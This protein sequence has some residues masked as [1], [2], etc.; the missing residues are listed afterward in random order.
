MSHAR[1]PDVL[2]LF[3][4]D[5]TLL[6]TLGAGIRGMNR[7]FGRLH[8][9]SDALDGVPVAGRTDRSIVTDGFRRIG[10]EPSLDRIHA[11]RDVYAGEIPDELD[12]VRQTA[13]GVLPGVTSMLDE[14]EQC[15]ETAVGLLTGNFETI[16]AIKLGFYGLAERF[17]FGGYGDHHLD[18]R[19][20]V[21]MALDR[22]RAA[23]LDAS[24][25]RV[26]VVG[27]TPLDVDCAHA[28]GAVAVAVA[29]GNYSVDEL[30]ATGADLVVETLEDA[31]AL[32]AILTASPAGRSRDS[33]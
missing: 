6:H 18:R 5:G 30:R 9:R 33:G 26:V 12:R 20:L 10:I 17:A 24:R 31:A 7:A 3:D 2:V 16:A 19:D 1:R 13:I 32:T 22:A 15:E 4:I 29:T 25:A 11:L 14:L 8:G 23:H 21:P 27:D 28:H